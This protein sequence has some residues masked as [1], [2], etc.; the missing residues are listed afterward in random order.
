MAG[1]TPGVQK[2]KSKVQSLNPET[3]CRARH[4]MQRKIE[5]S[6][7]ALRESVRARLRGMTPAQRTSAS[8]QACVLLKKQA[9]WKHARSV[10]FFAPL[11]EEL[12]VWPLIQDALAAGKL[13]ALPRF[14]SRT[15][16]YVACRIQNPARD[17]KPGHFGIREPDDCCAA[18]SPS[19]LDLVLVPGVAFDA[20]G[21]RLGRGKGYYDQL[22]ASVRGT[23]CGVAFDEQIVGEVP[24]EPHDVHLNCVLTPT[25]WIEA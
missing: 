20:H 18:V 11:P 13:V 23:S 1:A 12:D 10:L 6:K 9:I 16:R 4:K 17:L 19:R 25:R 24:V 8:A 5:D 7:S 15:D 21:R 2:P 3:T 22:L 14:D